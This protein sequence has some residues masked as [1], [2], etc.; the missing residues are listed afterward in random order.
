MTAYV[1]NLPSGIP[2]RISRPGNQT[3]EAAQPDAGRPFSAYGLP[4][5]IL[6][7]GKF[8][9]IEAGDAGADV[10]GF[11]VQPFPTT[12][13][14]YTMA[15]SGLPGAVPRADMTLSR[16]RR[17]YMTVRANGVGALYNPTDGGAVYVRIA[18]GTATNPIGGI[19]ARNTADVAAIPGAKF[20]GQ[21]DRDGNVEIE[22]N[23]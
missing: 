6:P 14:R 22:Y 2:G 5:K 20:R 8:V 12:D 17:G 18:N 1:L 11:L 21:R 13:G 10:A 19:E 15:T 3:V 23:I 4:G 7:N 9:P 16:L